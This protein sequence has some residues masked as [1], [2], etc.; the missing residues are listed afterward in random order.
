MIKFTAKRIDLEIEVE[1]MNGKVATLR[2][3]VPLTADAGAKLLDCI[4]KEE[5][6]FQ[7]STS[8]R[9]KVDEKEGEPEVKDL[10]SRSV[11]FLDRQ[12]CDIY[13]KEPGY[14]KDNFDRQTML[15]IKGYIVDEL[16]GIRKK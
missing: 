3:P 11:D 2:L 4:V 8:P 15:D 6:A 10:Y 7:E 12:L 16:N 13:G 1:D 9:K 5:S 14:W